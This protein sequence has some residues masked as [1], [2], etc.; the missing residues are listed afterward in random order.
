[1]YN[2]TVC[3]QIFETTS[4]KRLQNDLL[5][6]M[7]HEKVHPVVI[8]YKLWGYENKIYTSRLEK[9]IMKGFLH[10]RRGVKRGVFH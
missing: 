3:K 2:F 1:M 10:I 7:F 5:T 4:M 8:Y 9:Y 6:S